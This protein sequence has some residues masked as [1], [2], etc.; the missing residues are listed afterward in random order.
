MSPGVLLAATNAQLL[1]FD[2]PLVAEIAVQE[3]KI[4]DGADQKGDCEKGN[5]RRASDAAAPTAEAET[6]VSRGAE[7][8]T[9]V[10]REVETGVW[11][12]DFFAAF[13]PFGSAAAG[14]EP[15]IPPLNVHV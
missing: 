8:G 6:I 2:D 3:T 5:A 13:S 12:S 4:S 14:Q 7:V 10:S 15:V 9:I 1:P 11:I